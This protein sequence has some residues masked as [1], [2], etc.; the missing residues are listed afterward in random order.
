MAVG[1]VQ[2]FDNAISYFLHLTGSAVTAIWPDAATGTDVFCA[3][4][5]KPNGAQPVDTWDTVA[6]I[7][8][9]TEHPATGNY[10]QWQTATAADRIPAGANRTLAV[11]GGNNWEWRGDPVDFGAQGSQNGNIT[12]T[13]KFL[14]VAHDAD[15]DGDV[16]TTDKLMFWV[17]L[18]I[19]D[20]TTTEVTSTAS[21]FKV[22]QDAATPGGWFYVAGQS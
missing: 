6:N 14:L 15:G 19:A 21:T 18:D 13:A 9:I 2:M 1:T 5:W 8:T 22:S 7:A 12:A 3:S 10:V 17:N 16:E 20:T 4:L 11:Q